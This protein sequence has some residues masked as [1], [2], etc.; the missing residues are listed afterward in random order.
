MLLGL[1]GD[2]QGTVVNLVARNLQSLL[3]KQVNTASKQE[4]REGLVL[5]KLSIEDKEEGL[6][7]DKLNRQEEEEG[8]VLDK[9][10]TDASK[11]EEEELVE[12]KAFLIS[13]HAIMQYMESLL[14]N[15]SVG[16]KGLRN[17][18]PLGMVSY[19]VLF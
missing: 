16:E 17:Q 15:F 12:D 3:Q 8:L 4:E 10:N 5:E 1:P 2:Q 13:T 18:L 14:E 7:L 9:F 6:V 19:L 11:Q